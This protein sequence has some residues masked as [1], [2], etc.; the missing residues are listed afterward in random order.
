MANTIY[1]KKNETGRL[2]RVLKDVD[3]EYA[4]ISIEEYHGYRNALRIIK[5]RSLQEIEKAKADKYGY[6]LK[7]ADY[8]A[9]DRT[10]PKYKAYYITKS[11][12]ISLTIDAETA[13]F[14]IM[15]DL[16]S[17]Y[18]CIDITSITTKSFGEP[19]VLSPLDLLQAVKQRDDPCYAQDFYVDNN[20]KGRKIKELLDDI[21][22][23]II[24]EINRISSN[25]GQGIYELSYWA[26]GLI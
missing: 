13:Y 10:R 15:E 3:A 18:N 6:T 7:Y 4:M 11:T 16:Y 12:P 24:F 23:N 14:L 8:R 25:Y 2:F 5:D 19:F 21:D 26:T 22:D 1:M 9:Y 17:Y 20:D